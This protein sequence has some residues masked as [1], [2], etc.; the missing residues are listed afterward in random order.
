M[1]LVRLFRVLLGAAIFL[2][3][4]F[5]FEPSLLGG[6]LPADLMA[7]EMFRSVVGV[8]GAICGILV[9]F[10]ALFPRPKPQ[11]TSSYRAIQPKPAP[12]APVVEAPAVEA[13]AAEPPAAEAL[14]TE[15]PVAETP[16]AEPNV[17]AFAPLAEP[18][19]EAP[20]EPQP[21]EEAAELPWGSYVEPDEHTLKAAR[22]LVEADLAEGA[23][24]PVVG[25]GLPPPPP[26]ADD[27]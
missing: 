23:T 21:D 20:P 1:D 17:V 13:P 2:L 4:A 25:E 15:T 7:A 9:V 3:A 5:V 27:D 16:V 24:K 22:S 14:V 26:R 10:D 6:R 12:P 8:V 19:P 11:P 18:V